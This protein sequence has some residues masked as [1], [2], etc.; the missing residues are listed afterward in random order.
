MKIAAEKQCDPIFCILQYPF[1][2]MDW[3]YQWVPLHQPLAQTPHLSWGK[4]SIRPS[5]VFI[6]GQQV[7]Q[8]SRRK[9]DA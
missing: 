8:G 3:R 6:C 9:E 7:V 1:W 4:E 2:I 5:D